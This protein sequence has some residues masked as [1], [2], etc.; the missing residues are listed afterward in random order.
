M[1]KQLKKYNLFTGTGDAAEFSLGLLGSNF[2]LTKGFGVIGTKMG[3]LD[4]RAAAKAK[5]ALLREIENMPKNTPQYDFVKS[6]IGKLD[7]T[8]SDAM[9]KAG[10][11]GEKIGHK[12][13]MVNATDS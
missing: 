4:M 5:D 6:R 12:V 8:Y 3:Q 1:K 7:A 2:L 13:A 11:T 9:Y 10:Y